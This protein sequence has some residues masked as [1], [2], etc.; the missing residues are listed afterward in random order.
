MPGGCALDQGVS[1]TW[2]L[3]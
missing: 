2:I 3:C 1:K